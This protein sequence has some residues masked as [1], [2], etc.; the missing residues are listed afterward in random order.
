MHNVNYLTQTVSAASND[1]SNGDFALCTAVSLILG[2]VIAFCFTLKQK[3]S[4]SFAMTLVLL[5]MIVQVV[6]ML[7]NGNLGT[8]VA[9]MGA[10]SLVRF[11]SV[12]G[13]ARDICAIFLSMAAGLA[14]GTEHIALAV[15]FT[16]TVC[17]VGAVCMLSPI[18]ETKDCEKLLTVVIPENL[19]YTSAFDDIFKKHTDRSELIS[20]KTTNMGSLFKLKYEISV[21]SGSDEKQLIDELRCRNGNLEI[22]CAKLLP[23]TEQL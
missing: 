5:P 1:I 6:I 19:D 20:V 23:E 13:S 11:R 17:A 7:V 16:V 14:T 12:P 3:K 10:F 18:G 4:K 8:G 21:K 22:M 15:I 9:V 2:A